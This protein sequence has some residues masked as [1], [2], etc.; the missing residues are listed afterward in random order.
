MR[1]LGGAALGLVGARAIAAE[2]NRTSAGATSFQVVEVAK[3]LSFPWS[4][5]FLPD[6]RMLVTERAGALR[7]VSTSGEL[8]APIAGVPKVHAQG[9]GGLLDVALAADFAR[10][11]VV[12]LSYSEPTDSGARTAI[13]RAELGDAGL[14]NVKVIF[15]Q[16]QAASG[17][18]HFGSRIVVAPG[19]VLF[20]TM[21]DRYSERDRAQDLGTHFGK[22]VRI[23]TD[24]SVPPGNPF[25]K[26]PDALP[27]IWSYGHRNLQGATLHPVTGKLWT[28][29]HGPQGGDEI[30]VEEAGSNYGWPVITYGREYVTGFR[31]GEGTRRT[32]VKE[33]VHQWTP[34]IAPSGMAFY[35]GDRFPAWKG[36]LFVGS[37]KFQMLSRIE[38]DGEKFVRE[39]RLLVDRRE[40]IRDVRQGPDGLIYLLA[41]SSGKILR[42]EPK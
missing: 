27:D 17:N 22:I 41:E 13:A 40:R 6:G 25:A 38:L 3:G 37:L 1:V 36:N 35:T 21:G 31:I 19:S 15:A 8:S 26:A 10:S 39:E 20:V 33:P 24:G 5:A 29:E 30:N 32:D 12:F 23:R 4:L 11:R 14:A 7:F 2:D 28:H 9:Q 34:S 16:R 42:L 18:N